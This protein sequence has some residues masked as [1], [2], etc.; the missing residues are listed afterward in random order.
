M[1]DQPDDGPVARRLWV[2]FLTAAFAAIVYLATQ[3]G[4]LI[5]RGTSPLGQLRDYFSYDQYG[6]LAIVKNV[7]DGQFGLFEPDTMT[8][9]NYYPHAYYVLLGVVARIFA[10]APVTGWNVVGMTVQL[11][12][13]VVLALV[14]IRIGGRW[15]CGLFA[16]L[17]FTL[18]TFAW[19]FDPQAWYLTMRSHAVLWGAFGVLYTLNGESF[20]LCI[21]GI[22][23]LVL[24]A[25]WMR[26]SS[27]RLRGI[28]T[29]VV[30]LAF[31]LLASV[32]TYSF[33]A[34]VYCAF[35][36]AAIWTLHRYCAWKLAIL[37]AA[38]LVAAFIA[39]PFVASH[40]GQL[41]T[42]VFGLSSTIPGIVLLIVKTHG[43]AATWVAAIA[44]GAL[45]QV[46]LTVSGIVGHDPFLTYRVASNVNLGLEPSKGWVASL[47][48]VLPL[49]I[50][51]VFG[52]VRRDSRWTAY[53]LGFGTAWFLL[54]TNDLWGVNAEPYRLWIDGFTLVAMTIVPMCVSL[55][56]NVTWHRAGGGPDWISRAAAVCLAAS[57]VVAAASMVDWARFAFATSYHGTIALNDPRDKAVAAL[58]LSVNGTNPGP[59]TLV[60][61]CIDPKTM[62]INA[63]VATAFYHLGMAWPS[64]KAAIDKVLDARAKGTLDA[65]SARKAGVAWVITD[66]ECPDDWGRIY[67]AQLERVGSKAYPLSAGSRGTITIWRMR[68]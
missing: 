37:S 7:A 3:A 62:K 21:A 2:P 54:S 8:G 29:F 11:A 22:G 38:M 47:A 36:T 16:P 13:V 45:P 57:M 44:M 5:A 20:A 9:A 18:G 43:I 56:R 42:L 58:A 48:L 19:L 53:A 64:Q 23:A 51:G 59:L 34:I 61:N 60:D 28:T 49:I 55:A 24:I 27:Q 41:P 39:G 50:V 46:I 15:W 17:P 65:S 6:Y 35:F 67:A 40:V 12:L 30:C 26:P 10:V 14:L 25:I 1:I 66:S 63:G 68:R 33:I 32:Q 52:F 4:W 31:G